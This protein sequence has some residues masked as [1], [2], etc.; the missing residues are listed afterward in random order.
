[1]ASSSEAGELCFREM[2]EIPSFQASAE[3]IPLM[4]AVTIRILPRYPAALAARDE[5][6]AGVIFEIKIQQHEVDRRPRQ[7]FQ[8]FRRRAALRD[9]LEIRLR[10]QQ[11]AQSLAEQDVVVKQ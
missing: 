9:G 1:M 8:G 5:A 2:P 7:R 6:S 11:P 3:C 10:D 4:P